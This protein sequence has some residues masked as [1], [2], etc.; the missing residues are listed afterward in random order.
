MKQTVIVFIILLSMFT[1]A[2][3]ISGCKK[4]DP[5][6]QTN[7]F[8]ATKEPAQS[9]LGK[10]YQKAQGVECQSNLSQLR[11]LMQIKVD[12]TRDESGEAPTFTS[13][14]EIGAPSSVTKCPISK[15]P[16]TLNEGNRVT[17]TFEGHENF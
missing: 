11:Q 6:Q 7:E 2:V 15:K 12:E 1:F 17:C 3:T 16:Y 4:K 10:A 5:E 9:V 13:L 14:S 8:R